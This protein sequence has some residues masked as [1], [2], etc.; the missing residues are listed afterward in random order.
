MLLVLFPWFI[1]L[2][3]WYIERWAIALTCEWFV[4]EAYVN[5]ND[6]E[7]W[8]SWHTFI[9]WLC[10]LGSQFKALGSLMCSSVEQGLH[11]FLTSWVPSQCITMIS[12]W[13][14]NLRGAELG[15]LTLMT[16]WP[17]LALWLVPFLHCC[18]SL[19]SSCAQLILPPRLCLLCLLFPTFFYSLL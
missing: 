1:L 7:L 17:P 10:F 8:I 14:C 2:M 4:Q 13:I 19:C 9:L 6:G 5:I 18:S 16:S 3:V 11:G 12:N 15:L